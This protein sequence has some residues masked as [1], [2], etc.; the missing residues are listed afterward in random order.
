M[1]E[2]RFSFEMKFVTEMR[3]EEIVVWDALTVRIKEEIDE[4][5]EVEEEVGVEVEVDAEAEVEVGVELEVDAETE[6]EVEVGRAEG[7]G[8]F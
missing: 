6:V 3:E 5:V 8:F 7:V 4:D 2:I 1:D